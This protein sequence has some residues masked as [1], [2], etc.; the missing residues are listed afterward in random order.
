MLM[1][2][3]NKNLNSE[4]DLLIKIIFFKITSILFNKMLMK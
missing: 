2:I 3:V 1:F 4:S